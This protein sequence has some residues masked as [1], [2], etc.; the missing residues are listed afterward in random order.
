MK[1]KPVRSLQTRVLQLVLLASV[2]VLLLIG[3]FSAQNLQ[4]ARQDARKDAERL[5]RVLAVDHQ[6]MIEGARQVLTALT[7]VP[8]IRDADPVGATP[9]LQQLLSQYPQ[10]QNLR[11]TAPTGEMLASALPLPHLVNVSDRPWFQEILRVRQFR[12][13]HFIV[14]RI[15]GRPTIILALPILNEHEEVRAVVSAELDLRRLG[16]KIAA[17]PQP[18]DAVLTLLDYNG[19]ILVR[20][21]DP[22]KWAGQ[23]LA[24]AK[25]SD[26][27]M[28]QQTGF[29]E[30]PDV[31]GVPQLT[32]FERV[33]EAAG[34][35][36]VVVSIPRAAA[37]AAAYSV[38]RREVVLLLVVALLALGLSFWAI[39]RD[40]LRPVAEL[41]RAARGLA[42]G[43]LSV[44]ANVSAVTRE[45]TEVGAAFNDMA[46]ALQ[47][48]NR[49]LRTISLCNQELVRATHE[50]ELLQRICDVMVENGG[51][52]L[53]WIGFAEHDEARTVRPVAR[54]GHDDGY[55]AVAGIVWS[56]TE[57]G[58]G[59]TG[60]A[61]RTG[62]IAVAHDLATAPNDAPW[63]KEALRRGYRSAIALPLTVAGQPV[64][65]FHLYTAEPSAFDEAEV[66]L[67][68][69]LADD[70]SFG[71]A[72][73]RARDERDRAQALL[74]NL[75][76]TMPD[77]IYFKDRQG[78]FLRINKA[79]AR[80]FGLRD[81][82]EAVGKT[83]ADFFTAEH[84]RQAYED[85]QRVMAT[86]IAM[87]GQEEKETWPDG[88]VTW[89]ST[90]KVPLYD[91]DGRVVG[92][93][94]ISRDITAHKQAEEALRENERR[95][96]TL[97]ANL[98]GMAYRCQNQPDWPMEFVSEGCAGL[99]GWP[100]SALLQNRPAYGAL[101]VEADRQPVWDAVQQ[102][103][104]AR[105]FYEL[106]YRIQTADGQLR[107]VWERGCGVFAPDGSLLCLEGFITDITKRVQ[108]EESLRRERALL[109]R[110]TNFSPAGII[111]VNRHGH[112]TFANPQAEK[113][114]GLTQEAITQ[115]TYN[116]PAWLITDLNGGP[117]P[118]E[119]LPFRRVMATRQPVTD[120]RHAIKWPDGRRVLLSINGAP[121]LDAAGELE[122]AVFTVS[123]ITEQLRAEEQQKRLIR[124]VESAAESILITD[125]VGAI[126]YVNPAFERITGY[127]RAEVLGQ[128]PRILKSGRQDAE[129]YR[130]MWQTLTAGEVWAGHFINKKKDGTLYEEEATISPIRDAAGKVVNYVAVKRDV[131]HELQ[132]EQQLR[133]SQKMEAVGR[134]AGGVAHDFNNLLSVI[135]G[136]SNLLQ[137]ALPADPKLQ[138]YA[139]EI[140]NAGHRAAQLTRQLLAFSRKQILQPQVL[141]LNA[142]LTDLQKMLSRLIGEDIELTTGLASDLHRV[143]AD[144][145]QL[146][147][148]II[149][150]C[151][152]ARDAM[153]KGG[154]LRIETRNVPSA[155]LEALR[156]EPGTATREP[157]TFVQLAI[158]DTGI[159]MTP[160]VRAHLF[161]P[162]F[163]TK[164]P[165]KGTGLGLATVFGI[166]KQSGGFITVETEPGRG[167]TFRIYL[168]GCTE[169]VNQQATEAGDR[170]L[171]GG[172][173]T[174][175]VVEDEPTLREL[176]TVILSAAGYQVLTAANG[177]EGLAVAA[178]HT[179]AEIALLVTDV[180]MPQMGG[181]DLAD[182]LQARHPRLRVLFTS[183]Y[184]ANAIVHHGVLEHGIR[185]LQKPYTSSELLRKVREALDQ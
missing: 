69:E 109:E 164:E 93:M 57:R 76:T 134:L 183:G 78:R 38:L 173:E 149:N 70:I 22:E 117:F 145:G 84:A 83:D 128:N 123:D 25:L 126:Q 4:R 79:M 36:S 108:A 42:G 54:A 148:V 125:S 172:T 81:P 135:I 24:D 171:L 48:T 129:F 8:A 77:H 31:E 96:A 71:I 155:E 73:L 47:R 61:I 107:W 120:I 86:G 133:Q 184:T 12:V 153:P 157:A 64:G 18:R 138:T 132:V 131:T 75:L 162:F 37:Y 94:G 147:Q 100:A 111:V 13:G 90:T 11:L 167:T 161:E 40:I 21:R 1:A 175:L 112:I 163:T 85:E 122:G 130:R 29:I 137:P 159:G 33:S 181:R 143:K 15:S 142:V 169:A 114:L 66:Q 89:V 87:V 177:V 91:R 74:D 156:E 106:T 34:A 146:E 180:V 160:E 82:A 60:T 50:T 10:F 2:P 101:I 67:L 59:P 141:D 53:A 136:Y 110:I 127:T 124:A 58:R 92:L 151:V 80:S 3:V 62:Q 26:A 28:R 35:W 17:L 154:K 97:M 166:V 176:A 158:T 20:S 52:R 165:G 103:L 68:K 115:R 45:F 6:E 39:R 144:P 140:E 168:P 95:L 99:T 121:L 88:R 139:K 152:N 32:A 150:L 51:Y 7:H 98:P 104:Q 56:D 9:V 116:D 178:Q 118:D 46:A 19:R 185:F 27:I 14:G 72:A 65:A 119:D 182:R 170:A 5:A 55:L 30:G 44:R 105:Q 16:E 41:T 179:G 63:R 113:I 102:A 23:R 43:D 49:M 174:I